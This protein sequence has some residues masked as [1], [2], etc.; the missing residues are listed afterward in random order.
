M[1]PIGSTRSNIR[2]AIGFMSALP[3]VAERSSTMLALGSTAARRE[4]HR[5]APP[6]GREVGAGA[7]GLEAG[8]VLGCGARVE[9]LRDPAA[10]PSG[11][12]RVGVDVATG[13]GDGEDAGDSG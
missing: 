7:A 2:R 12:P 6:S 5:R 10:D 9:E 4:T 3:S 13:G 8:Q 1:T 11:L